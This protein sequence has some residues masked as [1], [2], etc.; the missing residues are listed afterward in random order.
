HEGADALEL[1]E[2]AVMSAPRQIPA[3]DAGAVWNAFSNSAH[4]FTVTVQT[5]ADAGAAAIPLANI[6]ARLVMS[7]AAAVFR[8]GLEAWLVVLTGFLSRVRIAVTLAPSTHAD[9]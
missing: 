6:A 4:V 9:P 7:T 2:S 3:P 1:G 5:T 8:R